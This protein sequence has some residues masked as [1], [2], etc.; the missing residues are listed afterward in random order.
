[1]YHTLLHSIFVVYFTKASR[2][3]LANPQI[4]IHNRPC[5]VT[6]FV[7]IPQTAKGL[8]KGEL[9]RIAKADMGTYLSTVFMKVLVY[10]LQISLYLD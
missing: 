1:M 7:E 8:D 10:V 9:K 3:I 5:T 4:S 2:Y 6:E